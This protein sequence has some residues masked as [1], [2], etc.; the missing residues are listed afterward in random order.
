MHRYDMYYCN[1]PAASI[2]ESCYSDFVVHCDHCD[3]YYSGDDYSGCPNDCGQDDRLL[4]YGYKPYPVFHDVDGKV[5][6]VPGVVYMGVELEM[7]SNDHVV[8]DCVDVIDRHLGSFAYCKEDGSL[9]HGLEMVT[10]PFTLEYAH[11]PNLWSVLDELRRMGC[12]SWNTTTCGMHIHVSRTAFDGS[13]HLFRFTQLVLKNEPA[14]TS[15]AGRKNDTYASFRDGYQ[16]GL[17]AKVIKGREYGATVEVRMFRGSLRINRLLANLE[18]VHAAVEYTRE[19]TVPQVATGG[20]SWRAFATWITDHR[21]RYSHLFE[22]LSLDPGTPNTST[23][24]D[25]TSF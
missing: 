20:L 8:N 7:E 3:E 11:K 4:N 18:F 22:Y 2:C 13:A 12:R 25:I 23:H 14:C 16:P 5:S 10:H 24:V 1:H 6:P 15:F 19:L 17:L 21:N 9:S